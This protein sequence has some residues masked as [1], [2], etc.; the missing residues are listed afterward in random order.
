MDGSAS[1][2]TLNSTAASQYKTFIKTVIDFYTVGKNKTN[3]GLMV[4]SSVTITKF[5]FISFYS[6]SDINNAIDTMDYPENDTNTGAAL[7]AVERNLFGHVH[8]GRP[9]CLVTMTDGVSNDDVSLPS[10]HLKAMKVITLAVGVGDYYAKED[11][12]EIANIPQHVFEVPV[13]DQLQ[14]TANKVKESLCNGRIL[15]LKLSFD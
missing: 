2:K 4:Y 6:K 7:A 9:N 10:A 14:V 1:M 3:V 12:E 11:L 8:T 15:K 13:Y 5:T